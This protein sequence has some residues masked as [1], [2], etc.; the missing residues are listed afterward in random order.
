VVVD[1][2]RGVRQVPIL[3][4]TGKN[5]EPLETYPSVSVILPARN[6]REKVESA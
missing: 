1:W 2:F 3:R 6:E 4:E 5:R